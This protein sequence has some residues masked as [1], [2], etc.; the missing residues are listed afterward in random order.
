M[1]IKQTWFFHNAYATSFIWNSSPYIFGIQETFRELFQL[2][3]KTIK[4]AI[5]FS[6]KT[7]FPCCSEECNNN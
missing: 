3:L 2:I 6:K 7:T 5:N 4:F 1:I